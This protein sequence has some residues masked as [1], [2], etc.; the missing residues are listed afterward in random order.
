MECLA[1]AERETVVDKLLVAGELVSPQDLVPAV[2]CI[3]EEWV[4]YVLHVGTYLVG[5]PRL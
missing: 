2:A 3:S 4:P 1:G 5:T